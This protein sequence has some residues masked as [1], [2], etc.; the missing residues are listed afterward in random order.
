MSEERGR[1]APTKYK[2]EFDNIAYKLS[3]LGLTD[4]EIADTLGITESTINNWKAKYPEFLESIK[5]GKVLADSEVAHSLYHRAKGYEHEED[6]IFLHEGQP[7]IVPTIKKYAPDTKAGEIW[8]RNRRGKDWKDEKEIT[9]RQV[10]KD[11]DEVF[12][13][14]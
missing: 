3:L 1:G 4:I 2:K 5:K 8:L 13:D 9:I 6:K 10:G 7:V 12:E 11:F 14:D